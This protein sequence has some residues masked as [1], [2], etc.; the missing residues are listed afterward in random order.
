MATPRTRLCYFRNVHSCFAPSD[1]AAGH[2]QGPFYAA[3]RHNYDDRRQFQSR[4]GAPHGQLTSTSDMWLTFDC[5]DGQTVVA[6][7]LSLKFA[8][9]EMAGQFPDAF[10]EDKVLFSH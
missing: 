4:A 2:G 3:R 7:W 8:S 9:R 10:E 6:Q 1:F 5:S